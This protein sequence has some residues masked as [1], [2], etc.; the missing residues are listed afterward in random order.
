MTLSEAHQN[1]INT[2]VNKDIKVIVVLVSGRPLVTTKQIEQSDAF[3]AAW[4]LGSEGNGIAEVLFGDYNFKGKL[5]HSW[6][7]SEEDYRD[8]FGPNFWDKSI[9]P[10]YEFGY[11]LRY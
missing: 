8:R 1:Y 4:L 2:Y 11:G 9:T 5:P 3:I 10:L 7:K 6:P